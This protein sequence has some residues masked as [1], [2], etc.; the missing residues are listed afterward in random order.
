MRLFS[1]HLEP[2]KE[3]RAKTSLSSFQFAGPGK[4]SWFI[5]VLWFFPEL[6]TDMQIMKARIKTT[7]TAEEKIGRDNLETMVK[8]LDS[9]LNWQLK[10]FEPE[11]FSRKKNLIKTWTEVVLTQISTVL[12]IH[13]RCKSLVNIYK[14][15]K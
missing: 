11:I 3:Q 2:P 1:I 7:I 10:K 5:A 14:I 13:N 6:I 4:L 15:Y 12:I 9:S 8:Y